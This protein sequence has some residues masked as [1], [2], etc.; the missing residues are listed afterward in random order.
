MRL[1][2]AQKIALMPYRHH[3]T[4]AQE[5]VTTREVTCAAFIKMALERSARAI[6][7]V[8]RGRALK[9]ATLPHTDVESL[10]ADTSLHPA[11]LTAAGVSD[12]ADEFFEKSDR[13]LAI[14]EFADNYLKSAGTLFAE[15]LV[16]RYLLTRG[17]TLGGE[18]RNRIGAAAQER[19]VR[20]I[21]SA[22]ELRKLPFHYLDKESKKWLKA[23]ESNVF[24]E[25]RVSRL[26]WEVSDSPRTL[27]F[28]MKVSQIG[29]SG[30][31][32]DICLLNCSPKDLDTKNRR[33]TLANPDTYLVLGELKGG[34]DPAGADEHWKTGVTALDRVRTVLGEPAIIFIGNAIVPSMSEEMWDMLEDGRLTNVANL[35]IDSQ[36]ASLCS[37]LV[38]L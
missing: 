29:K 3:L 13:E 18:M 19:L 6:P 27:T 15:E 1:R 14:V 10:V 24:L 30:N 35:N 37:W 32:V 34:N 33:A 9:A 20:A 21:I 38:N 25:Q 22:L 2:L 26:F 8:E 23:K 17:D 16:Y 5:L 4:S 28:N 11:I 12:K 31:N 7:Y 36:I